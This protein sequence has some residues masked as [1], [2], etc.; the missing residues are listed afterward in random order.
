VRR[1]LGRRLLGVEILRSGVDLNNE[2]TKGFLMGVSTSVTWYLGRGC[3]FFF[4][5]FLRFGAEVCNIGFGFS[6]PL[7]FPFR[8]KKSFCLCSMDLEFWLSEFY[9]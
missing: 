3:C 7:P 9:T 8:A 4:L 1:R 2:R 6:L 5:F